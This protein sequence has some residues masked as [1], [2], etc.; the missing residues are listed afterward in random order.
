MGAVNCSTPSS[1]CLEAAGSSLPENAMEPFTRE[2]SRIRSEVFHPAIRV[3][4]K[5]GSRK[6][7][8]RALIFLS[9]S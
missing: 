4:S 6:N 5:S 8:W 1:V 7:P 2:A 3:N 9:G